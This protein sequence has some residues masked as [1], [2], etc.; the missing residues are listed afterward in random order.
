MQLARKMTPAEVASGM[1][2]YCKPKYAAYHGSDNGWDAIV[3]AGATQ[4]A[5]P[6]DFAKGITQAPVPKTTPPPGPPGK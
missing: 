2:S 6:P 1:E 4:A 3:S 5:L